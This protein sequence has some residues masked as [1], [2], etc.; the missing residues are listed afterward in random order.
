MNLGYIGVLLNF[1]CAPFSKLSV[2][3]FEDL[4]IQVCN[5]HKFE[6]NLKNPCPPNIWTN[7]TI[8]NKEAFRKLDQS[9]EFRLLS[10][11]E[12]LGKFL[13]V[14]LHEGEENA[15]GAFQFLKALGTFVTK[16]ATA[17]SEFAVERHPDM[18]ATRSPMLSFMNQIG[19]TPV[20][21]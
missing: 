6:D 12:S 14:I 16:F 21:T 2:S 20:C 15:V 18:V 11:P 3:Y 19:F 1:V 10:N 13:N 9:V 8:Y 5:Y 17:L 4:T 7:S